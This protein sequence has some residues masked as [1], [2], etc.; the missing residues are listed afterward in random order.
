MKVN[1]RLSRF[2]LHGV[3]GGRRARR[4][5]RGYFLVLFFFV[6]GGILTSGLLEIYFSYFE[7]K[8]QISQHQKEVAAG[9]AFK[10]Q[11]FVQEIEK[12]MR[13]A[14]KS[15][16][17]VTKGLSPE[18]E[19]E[20][21]KLLLIAPPV[22]EAAAM[23]EGGL[24]HTQVSRLRTILPEDRRDLSLT[25]AFRHAMQG[26]P[27]FSPVYFIQDSEP[28]MTIAVPIERFA[29]EI[30][31]VLQAEVNLKYIWDLISSI[32]VGRAGYAYAVTRYGDLIAH[33]DIS[34]VLQKRNLALLGQVKE[35]FSHSDPI[36][37]GPIGMISKNLQ[38]KKVFSAHAFMP[39]LNWAVII[40][41]P[42]EDAYEKLY[43]SLFRTSGLLLLGLVMTLLASLYM[44]HRVIRP[45]ETLRRGAE[46][47]GSGNLGH[48][49]EINTSDELGILAEEFNKMTTALQEAYAGLEQKVEER[50][51]EL[52]EANLKLEEARRDLEEWN[53]TLEEKVQKQ[54]NELGRAGR[55]KRFLSP[56]VAEAV[57]NSD[58]IDPFQ[59]HRREVTVIFIDLRGFTNF[60]DSH[61]PEEVMQLLRKYHEEVGSLIF[62]YEGTLEHFAGD[63][64]MVFF[65]DPLPQEDHTELAT[66]MGIDVQTRINALRPEWR[67]KGYE[68]DVGIGIA[69]GFATLGAIGFEGRMDYGA[70]GNV[71]IMA[72]RLSSEAQ[73]GQ[74][75]TNR[76]T[77]AKIEG[78]VESEYLGEMQLKG[79][80]RPVSAFN[81][82]KLK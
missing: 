64:I 38:G 30:I 58:S 9:A 47:I 41:Q 50:T 13:M 80:T 72:S 12:T 79:F 74:I 33:P 44:A 7:S 61:E 62:K 76:K 49:L 25:P 59:T 34:L 24:V 32:Q 18:F 45:L 48:R 16:E 20:L 26:K 19:F 5:V 17:V 22:T 60:S 15:R 1:G 39:G 63:G 71:T 52:V 66:R 4:L 73:G 51:K 54:V 57:L 3:F 27:Y 82:S 56:Q 10:I 8:E 23:D 77:L 53:Q 35:A 29:G 14:T 65:N 75:L 40:E 68:L 21:R 31:G 43:V 2:S 37:A 36:V 67:R 69:T 11:K 70:I 81:I 46:L 55:I 78:L 28:Y 42:A 6:G